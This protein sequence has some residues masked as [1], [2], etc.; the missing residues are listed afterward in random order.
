MRKKE[1]IKKYFN[2]VMPAY[3]TKSSKVI[4]RLDKEFKL[5]LEAYCALM[6]K[7][8]DMTRLSGVGIHTIKGYKARGDSVRYEGL[9]EMCVSLMVEEMELKASKA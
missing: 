5:S 3:H 4:I 1:F 9:K 2:G 6:I 8:L 7:D